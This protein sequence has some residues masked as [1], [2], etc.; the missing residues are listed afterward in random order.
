MS[1]LLPYVIAPLVLVISA[2]ICTCRCGFRSILRPSSWAASHATVRS[3]RPGLRLIT[4]STFYVAIA[5]GGLL[6]G[7]FTR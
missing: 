2:R 3:A 4:A 5:A 6:G 1:R 7:V